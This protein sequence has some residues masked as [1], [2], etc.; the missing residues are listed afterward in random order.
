MAIHQDSRRSLNEAHQCEFFHR[1]DVIEVSR[2][3]A[4]GITRTPNRD[5][6][7]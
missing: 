2:K 4:M 6:G 1:N 7:R 3:Q 5:M